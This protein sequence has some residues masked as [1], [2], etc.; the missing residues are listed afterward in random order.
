MAEQNAYILGTEQDELHRLGIQH[1]VWSSEA[2][3][4]WKAAGFTAGHTILDLGCGPGYCAKEL[5]YI[6]GNTGKVIGVDKSEQYLNFL[7]DIAKKYGLN[8]TTIHSDIKVLKLPE[9]TLDGV[10]SRW[11]LAWV[12][13]P[14]EVLQNLKTALK[15]GGKIVLHEYYDWSTHQTEP[16][17]PA[18]TKAIN[19]AL[20]SF[21]DQ[22]GEIDVGRYLP[23]MLHKI[24][25]KVLSVRPMSKIATPK[26]FTWQWPETFYRIYFNKLAQMNYLQQ[27]EAQQALKE[28]DILKADEN[29]TICCP[30]MFE[31][32]AEKV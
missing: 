11:A 22:E 27:Q 5:A 24:G 2:H 14:E 23:N 25:F 21:K 19:A 10:Y 6:V 7:N 20:K 31:V 32:I 9:N 13:N 15:K 28:L 8:I 30:L 16:K 1:Q 18:L 29:A 12:N 4:G 26:T 3:K 17:L